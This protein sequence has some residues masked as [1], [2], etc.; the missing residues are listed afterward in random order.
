MA[1]P[2]VTDDLWI[3]VQPLLP[4]E[5]AKPRGGRPRL[6]DRHCLAG[7]LF[8]LRTG[9]PW[10]DL[11]RELGCGPGMTCWRRL[12]DW[13][14]AGVWKRLQHAL[15]TRLRDADRIDWT[16]AAVDAS[17]VPA[18]RGAVRPARIRRTAANRARSAIWWSTP[19]A[20][21]SPSASRRRTSARRPSSPQS[22]TPFRRFAGG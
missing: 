22:S 11:P 8:V 4:C 9:L 18:R 21:R 3:I 1:R 5:P 2:L 16:R 14:E 12:R 20:S 15:L 19:R 13:Q 10:G 6:P 7:I 17:T